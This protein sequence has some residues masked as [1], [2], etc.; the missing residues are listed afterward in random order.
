MKLRKRN[1]KRANLITIERKNKQVSEQFRSIRSN[2]NFSSINSEFRSLVITSA[3]SGD[4]KTITAANLAIVFS[5]EGKK[6][7]LVDADMRKPD[8][9]HIFQLPNYTG[10]SNYLIGQIGIEEMIRKTYITDLDIITSGVIPPNPS[11][12]LGSEQMK[13]FM[14]VVMADYDVVIFDTPPVLVVTDA[15]LIANQ[16]DGT[17]VVVRA[18]KNE[19][20]DIVKVKEQLS[21]AGANLVGAILNGKKQRKDSSYYY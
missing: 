8:V 3:S 14:E 18:K 11:E 2:I 1:L 5:Q 6:V 4:G 19:M 7:L 20:K 13:Q 17:V 21:F 16:C 9:H 10:L 12:L 15:T